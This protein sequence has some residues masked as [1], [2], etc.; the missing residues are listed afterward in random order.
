MPCHRAVWVLPDKLGKLLMS[1]LKSS[2]LSEIDVGIVLSLLSVM[3]R[4]RKVQCWSESFSLF[5]ISSRV[6]ARSVFVHD[7]S[8]VK[9]Q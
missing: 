9:H 1:K 8:S 4:S 5:S 6:D 7:S 3:L 2:R